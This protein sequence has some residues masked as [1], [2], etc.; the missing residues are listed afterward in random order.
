MKQR[1]MF[2]MMSALCCMVIFAAGNVYAANAW[3]TCQVT[4]AGPGWGDT[5]I[6][7]DDV[8]TPGGWA[9]SMWFKCKLAEAKQCLATAFTAMS[10]GQNVRI[11]ADLNSGTYPVLNAIYLQQAP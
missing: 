8:D 3:Y 4:E 7:L 9:G 1:K 10:N 11:N 5:Y 2:L 6:R